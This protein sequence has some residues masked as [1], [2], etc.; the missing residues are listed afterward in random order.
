M[1]QI[2]KRFLALFLSVTLVVGLMPSFAWA[3]P[4]DETS[5]GQDNVTQPEAE[6]SATLEMSQAEEEAP[7]SA[8]FVQEA[9][10]DASCEDA[11]DLFEFV[12]IDQEELTAGDTQQVAIAFVDSTIAQLDPVLRYRNESTGETL[13]AQAAAVS[14]NAVLYSLTLDEEG[15]YVLE[16][17]T[18]TPQG[19]TDQVV[20]ALPGAEE[21]EGA[22]TVAAAAESDLASVTSLT[23]NAASEEL[24]SAID[25]A[26]DSDSMSAMAV[27][28]TP[29]S[30]TNFVVCLDP[31]HAGCESGATNASAGL[32][33]DN[34]TVAIATY[35]KQALE[36]AGVTVV[37]T[38]TST[39]YQGMAT[40]EDLIARV[41][42]AVNAGA[43]VFV[44]FHIN[45]AGGTGFEVWV[46]NDSS[47]HYE[48]HSESYTLGSNILDKLVDLGLT[49]RRGVYDRDSDDY[50]Y[51]DGSVADYLSVLRNSRLNNI[52]AVL[53][54][55]GFIDNDSDVAFLSDEAC[56]KAMGE[57]DAQAIM[58]TYGLDEQALAKRY[59]PIFDATYYAKNNADVVAAVGSDESKLLSHFINYGMAEGRQGCETFDVL[60]YYNANADLRR[61]YGTSKGWEP[62]YNHYLNYGCK[63]SRT[64][65]G[66]KEL[67]SY[68]SKSADGTNWSGVYD[69]AYYLA[70]NADLSKAFTVNI[71]SKTVIDDAAAVDHFANYGTTEGRKGC[72]AFEVTSYYYA[73]ADLR[74][75]YGTTSGWKPYFQH[76]LKYGKNEKRV[77]TGVSSQTSW[78]TKSG[79][80]DWSVVYN[81]EYYLGKYADLKNAFTVKVGFQTVIDDK[82]AI[83][84]F[85]TCGVKEGRQGCETFNVTSY[86][87]ANADLRRAYGTSN[88]W[89]PY[90]Q[91]YL[92]YGCKEKR[93]ATGVT[94]QTSWLTKSADGVDWAV[95]YDCSY[96]LGKYSDLKNAFTRKVGFQT[97]VDDAAAVDHF[98]T[99]GAVEGR[100]GSNAF[101]VQSYYRQNPDLRRAFGTSWKLYY[102]HY[103]Q[104]GAAEGRQGA[105][106]SG[107]VED[108]TA[109][110]TNIMGTSLTTVNQ[111]VKRYQAMGYAYPSSVYA[112]YGA[113]DI[114]TFCTI[115]L[116]EANAEGVRAEVVFAQSMHETGWLQYGGDVSVEQCNFAGIG[117]T[118]N[119]AKGNSFSSVREGLRAQ[120]QHLKAYASTDSLNQA[121]VDPR[122]AYVTRGCAPTVYD[123]GGRWATGSGYGDALYS[124][125]TALLGTAA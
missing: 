121:C 86:Y 24:E 93:V 102:L 5:L 61:A 98:A 80:T 66:C 13:S 120:V 26:L 90:F 55:H 17:V 62:Y 16:S 89:R 97:V 88:G 96:Y 75:A 25:A 94:S 123:L 114:A 59:A 69:G 112:S 18:Y 79:G 1:K 41:N 83:D 38:R 15:T 35:C 7:V 84:H 56:L 50:T 58:E 82:A 119:G 71:G 109:S 70:K 81:C 2:G 10:A 51:P 54:E 103:V 36:A 105:G 11:A 87:Y 118:G 85:A 73:N 23:D 9:Q 52:P 39:A 45:A 46:Q 21:G 76:Y 28:A 44:S 99:F 32:R 43:D 27:E 107:W 108:V 30:A 78:L 124:Q 22:F 57:A 101:D 29:Q 53:I 106:F 20:L 95:C 34:L 110:S 4:Q 74:A 60:S 33:E 8:L 125:M 72:E 113:G 64:T 37:M 40:A 49:R 63:E 14:D 91:H 77:T 42:V 92:T 65:T 12:Y 48:L 47:Y 111:M 67:R 68:L 3:Q 115:L 117:A 116:Q 104:F 122:F 19:S 100:Q 6:Q 31:G